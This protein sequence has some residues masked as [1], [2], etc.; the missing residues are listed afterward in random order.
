MEELSL[1]IRAAVCGSYDVVVVGGG[2]AGVAAALSAGR[3]GAKTLLIE[4]SILLGGLAT[5]GHIAIY[6]PLCD[7]M[8]NKVIG[9]VAEE[10]LQAS[11]LY[12]H[13]NLPPGW[14]GQSPQGD[15]SRRYQTDFNVGAFACRL[16]QLLQ[17]AGVDILFDTLFCRVQ[18][19]G[20]RCECVVVENKAGCQAYRGRVV[21]DA[22]GDADVFF[23]A[24]FP[25]DE[26]LNQLSSWG[27]GLDRESVQNAVQTGKT[28]NAL[29]TLILGFQADGS[30]SVSG[31][32][33]YNGTDPWDITE[34]ALKS[35]EMALRWLLDHREQEAC[36]AAL[37]SMAQ[38]RTTRKI[39]GRATLREIDL[40]ARCEESVGCVGDWRKRG[41]V[42]EVPYGAM[43]VQGADNLLAA[44]RIIST[45]PE[46]WEVTRVIPAAA[47]TGQA[48]GTAAALAAR[49]GQPVAQVDTEELQTTLART[50]A[51]L[52][53]MD[54]QQ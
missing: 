8:G 27:Y 30:G 42:Y 21:I 17:E 6:L 10:L 44:G 16:D 22:S 36:L 24:G 7:G 20:T 46:L 39:R 31:A 48:A 4:K 45:T 37:A 40:F 26:Q 14:T 15:R 34:F 9:G 32:R 25:C 38:F 51:V 2:V 41:P 3:L 13:N 28:C 35:R 1:Q 12:G 43:H 19:E 50:G 54:L 53:L 5:A 49:Y 18:M 47:M 23:R 11:I 52:H 33:E 29:K